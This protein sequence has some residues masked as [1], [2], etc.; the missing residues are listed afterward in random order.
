[1]RSLVAVALYTGAGPFV[2]PVMGTR[3]QHSPQASPTFYLR[4]HV[5]LVFLLSVVQ[6]ICT[7]S[8]GIGSSIAWEA[9]HELGYEYSLAR[10]LR[11]SNM[12]AAGLSRPGYCLPYS[13]LPISRIVSKTILP[14]CAI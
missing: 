7:R 8:N 5:G 10:Q 9:S 3:T 12:N 6:Y 1:V 13:Y 2:S 11:T 4:D 14:T